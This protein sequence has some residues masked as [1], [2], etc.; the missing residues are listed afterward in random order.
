MFHLWLSTLLTLIYCTLHLGFLSGSQA[1]NSSRQTG[2]E[3]TS[4]HRAILWAPPIHSPQHV[5]IFFLMA[6]QVGVKLCVLLWF[7][8]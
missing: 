3:D 8:I 2:V 5:T 7:F 4:D 1:W 6:I